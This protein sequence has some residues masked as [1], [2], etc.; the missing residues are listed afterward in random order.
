MSAFPFFFTFSEK[1]EGN[2]FIA[3]VKIMG[4]LLGVEESDSAYW[5]YGVQP[6]GIAATGKNKDEAYLEFRRTHISILFDMVEEASDFQQFELQVERFFNEVCEET[7]Q[8]W[9]DAVKAVRRGDIDPKGMK[10]KKVGEH[11][12][13]VFVRSLDE[14]I[15]Q[16]LPQFNALDELAE[17]A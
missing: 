15:A 11:Q 2:G 3:D 13:Y 10:I 8:E 9:D 12:P 4:M 6:G 17:A 16:A 1:V 5:M 7:K 14:P